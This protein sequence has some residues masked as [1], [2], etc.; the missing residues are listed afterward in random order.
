MEFDFSY[1]FDAEGI[2]PPSMKRVGLFG[3]TGSIGTQTLE[4]IRSNPSLFSATLLTAHSNHELLIEQALE[5]LPKVV[6][7]TQSSKY[8]LV[9]EALSPK[10]IMVLAGEEALE[11]AAS[12]DCFDLMMAMPCW[13]SFQSH[14]KNYPYRLRWSVHRQKAQLPGKCKKGACHRPSE[15]EHGCQDF[16]RLINTDE[17]RP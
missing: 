3:S 9:K 16:H 2:N 14:R 17:Q 12:M 10:G 13:G 7:I 5:F 1:Q 15:L 11:E 8:A 4:V 6:V